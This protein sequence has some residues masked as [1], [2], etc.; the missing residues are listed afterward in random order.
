M[1]KVLEKMVEQLEAIKKDVP[2]LENDDLDMLRNHL[3]LL[4]LRVMR[5]REKRRRGNRE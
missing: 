5:V 3:R 2:H 1:N 4:E